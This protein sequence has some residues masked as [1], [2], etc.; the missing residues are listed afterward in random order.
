[1]GL[2]LKPGLKMADGAKSGRK[3]EAETGVKLET[4][5]KSKYG[6]EVKI[7]GYYL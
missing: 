5:A 7:L 4:D 1:M 6:A 2:R 3:T